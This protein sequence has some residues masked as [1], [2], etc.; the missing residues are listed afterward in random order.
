MEI[1]R[2]P[3]SQLPSRYS[4]ARSALY[5]RLKDL[6]IEPIKEGR[7]AYID[8]QQLQLLD[9]LHQHIQKGGTTNQRRCIFAGLYIMGVKI[10]DHA[11][12]ISLNIL[13]YTMK[14]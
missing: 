6:N 11:I 2:I 9:A 1:D 10:F 4:I 5:T 14:R 3:L 7:K 12:A 8:G 13:S